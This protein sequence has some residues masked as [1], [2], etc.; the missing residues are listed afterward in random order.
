MPRFIPD[1]IILFGA[2][3]SLLTALGQLT[4][5]ERRT[6]NY[7]LSLLFLVMGLCL[8]QV[9]FIGSGLHLENPDLL[10]LFITFAY[11]LGPILFTAYYYVIFPVKNFPIRK[12]LLF[13]PSLLVFL[14]DIYY[15]L[16]PRGSQL[17]ILSGLFSG[18]DY[19]MLPVL[20]TVIG[21]ASVQ[22]IAYL[23]FLL[24]LLFVEKKKRE[25]GAIMNVDIVY[26]FLSMAAH[27]V[28]V[29]GALFSSKMLISLGGIM[30]SLLLICAYV[31]GFRFPEFLQLLFIKAIKKTGKPPIPENE[32]TPIKEQLMKLMVEEKI[33]S[34]EDITLQDIADELSLTIHQTSHLINEHFDM[35]FNNFINRFRVDEARKIL[36][37]NPSRSIISIA[38]EVGFSSKSA[39][40]SAFSR[41]TGMTPTTFRREKPQK[42]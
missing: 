1:T 39:F 15:L 35:N 19:P 5:R 36:L 24:Y 33:Y 11:L 2:G 22:M 28:L 10:F 7:N 30:S 6:E 41:F 8:V 27:T 25:H 17:E 32:T 37:E 40:Y 42:L 18:A 20:K 38:H 13:L 9:Y 34:E 16:L 3:L 31:V 26:T 14:G 29:S 12:P 23:S 4:L 21:G